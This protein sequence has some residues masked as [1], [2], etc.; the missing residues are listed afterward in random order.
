MSQYLLP[1]EKEETVSYW[2]KWRDAQA[3]TTDIAEEH[4]AMGGFDWPDSPIFPYTDQ[5]NA[6]EGIC[7]IS[8]CMGHR[9]HPDFDAFYRG[10]LWFRLSQGATAIFDLEVPDLI[11]LTGVAGLHKNYRLADSPEHWEWYEVE[12]W[13][14]EETLPGVIEP[15][16]TFFEA[17]YPREMHT[18]PE[19]E[20]EDQPDAVRSVPPTHPEATGTAA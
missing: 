11:K 16:I 10:Y 20:A 3:P 13:G 9:I 19:R 12:F 14:G 17:T 18:V 2:L 5:I 15:I 4:V 1:Q 8:S 7:T 6:L